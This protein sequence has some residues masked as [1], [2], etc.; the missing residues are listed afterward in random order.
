MS[1]IMAEQVRFITVYYAPFILIINTMVVFDFVYG[2]H[3]LKS[4]IILYQSVENMFDNIPAV[5]PIT[6]NLCQ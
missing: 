2:Q 5:V 1:A 6:L 3:S 4:T